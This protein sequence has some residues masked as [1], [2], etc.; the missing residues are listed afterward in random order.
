MATLKAAK[1]GARKARSSKPAGKGRSKAVKKATPA[2][3]AKRVAKSPP[4]KKV[5][6]AAKRPAATKRSA[7]KQAKPAA[8][9]A[10]AKKAK[11]AARAPVAKK[12]APAR[13]P[14]SAAAKKPRVVKPTA[15]REPGP[16]LEIS[17]R[18][19]AVVAVVE[20]PAPAAVAPATMRGGMLESVGEAAAPSA[21]PP[22]VSERRWNRKLVL[23]ALNAETGVDGGSPQQRGIVAAYRQSP[24]TASTEDFAF[25]GALAL[26]NWYVD[27]SKPGKTERASLW[28]TLMDLMSKSG[29][30]PDDW[31]PED[32]V[33]Q[34]QSTAE[35]A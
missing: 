20:A 28:I 5:K 11:T 21:A 4:A 2:K 30:N 16:V 22:G 1:K 12:S 25:V 10:P 29:D 15:P 3:K 35:V 9:T 34:L 23:D 8:R 31:G 14:G 19:V 17:T 26:K 6:P 32:S 18:T 24:G 33:S 27:P 13:A 7:A